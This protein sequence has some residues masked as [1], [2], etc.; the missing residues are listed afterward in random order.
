MGEI[1]ASNIPV[2]VRLNDIGA[3]LSSLVFGT[4]FMLGDAPVWTLNMGL[5]TNLSAA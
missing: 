1:L 4:I 3:K 2:P 5:G